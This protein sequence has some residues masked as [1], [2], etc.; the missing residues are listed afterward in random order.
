MPD[1]PGKNRLPLQRKLHKIV[2]DLGLGQKYKKLLTLNG[3]EA[4]V[5]SIGGS[6]Q[7]FDRINP[8]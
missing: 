2:L 1:K 8:Q 4:S 6:F 5:V 7:I 3:D